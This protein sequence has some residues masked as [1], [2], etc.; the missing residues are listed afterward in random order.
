MGTYYGGTGNDTVNA[1]FYNDVV[2][3][4][5]G[6]DTVNAYG[7]DDLVFGGDGGDL[8]YGGSGLD[9]V[10]GE[11]GNDTLQGD[12]GYD[13]MFGGTGDDRLVGA[14]D[15][16]DDFY[17]GDG[18]DTILAGDYDEDWAWGE[19]GHDSI[20]MGA[21]NDLAWG[22]SGNDTVF[23]GL[24]ADTVQGGS[25]ADSVS[26][27]GG[28]DLALGGAGND[29]VSGGAENDT[30]MGGAGSDQLY[31]GTGDDLIRGDS[32]GFDGFDASSGPVDTK[33]TVTNAS[34][35]AVDLYWINESGAAVYTSTLAPGQSWTGATGSTHTWYLSEAG[36]TQP[37]EVIHGAPNQT[38]SFAPPFDDT[39]FGGDGRDTI[40]GD[41]GN[42]SISGDAGNDSLNAG[43]GHDTILGGIGDDIADLGE[44]ND[45]FGSWS[46]EG[47]N[48]TVYGGAGNDH[49]IGGGENDL[50][51][52]GT[53]DDSL[54]GGAGSDSS[55]GGAGNDM[56]GITDDHNTDF[57]DLGENDGDTDAI[58]FSNYVSTNGVNVSFSGTDAGSYSFGSGLATG[59][60]TGAEWL[61]GTSYADTLNAGADV[62]GVTLWG[63]GGADSII[64]G[65]GSD[66]I[67]GGDGSDTIYFGAGAGEDTVY[68][69][70]GN[71]LIDD[72]G[73]TI[74]TGA[75]FVDAGDG[76][77]TIW[78][79][80]GA[81]SVYGGDGHDR[82]HAETG[83]DLVHAGAGD[84]WVQ[85]DDGNDSL[86]GEAGNDSLLG[87]AGSDTLRGGAGNDWLSGGAGADQYHLIEAGG[88]DTIADFDMGLISGLTTD[89]LDVSD[90]C[91]PD[92]SPVRAWNV[93]VSDDGHGN[94]RLTFPQGES[95]LLQG[96]SPA[97]VSAPG[98]L[99]AMG[100][101]CFA[102]GTRLMTPR[103][104]RPVERILPGDLVSLATGGAAPVLWVGHRPLGAAAL[105]ANP[106]LRPIH[107]PAGSHGA[108][109]DLLLS[110]QHAVAVS[111]PGGVA[112]VR[113]GHLARL[114][115][116]ARQAHRVTRITY[117]HLLLPR[118]ALV[119][120]EGA[121]VESLFPGPQL[122]AALRPADR[123]RLLAC[124]A[125]NCPVPPGQTPTDAYGARCLPLL[126]FAQA[127][128]WQRAILATG[129][130]TGGNHRRESAMSLAF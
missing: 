76:D 75:S 58:W 118:H 46:F 83:D 60:F 48:D 4:Y 33:L 57:Y 108:R 116:A 110:P 36:S 80:G 8:V 89:Q 23:G 119:L 86:L 61:G 127:R 78:S 91:N 49:I 95:L 97:S 27:D 101:P 21:G 29:T 64:G 74:E 104:P 65:S 31:G 25:G 20:S 123:T 115:W 72:L 52:G 7:G 126:G 35:F 30:V 9:T 26:G 13:K 112:L 99:A 68:G 84:D 81:D 22:G 125:R 63:Q 66:V 100:V 28:Q 11:A 96:I 40:F 32:D 24:G 53:G 111:G 2:H 10:Q 79:G 51:Y 3:A 67:Y 103:G 15:F 70:S 1:G 43:A 106:G 109:H 113:A 47:G 38:V 39:I 102:A 93:S 62:D 34:G 92:D 18:N 107:I 98:M 50:L 12:A 94:A 19:A 41:Y 14:S 77:D 128:A 114:G 90:L 56:A 87:G 85:G 45:S 54:F 120:A 16:Y 6:N 42:D 73:G 44:G 105:A 17:G 55:Y 37:I 59:S 5:G 88:G 121:Q 69:G 129:L 82:V 71:D 130:A 124:L 122:L 117:H